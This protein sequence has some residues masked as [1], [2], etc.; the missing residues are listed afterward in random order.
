MFDDPDE[1]AVEIDGVDLSE[2][3]FKTLRRTVSIVLQEPLLFSGT[4]ASNLKFG[5]PEASDEEMVRV[6][7]LVG[8]HDAVMRL[9]DGYDT[10]IQER[11]TNLSYG[12]RQLICLGRALLPDPRILVFDEATS[13]VDPYTEALIQK[14]HLDPIGIE[15]HSVLFD[16]ASLGMPEYSEKIVHIQI[17]NLNR[18]LAGQG[19]EVEASADAARFLAHE[20]FDPD[21]GARPLKRTIQRLL[22]DPLASMVLAGEI[23]A[24]TR[25]ELVVDDGALV[26]RPTTQEGSS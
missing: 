2:M 19:L 14:S 25:I 26:L 11:G 22:Q 3:G 9:V 16:D 5:R 20:G 8:V 10:E 4:I 13:S 6:A 21:F 24:G 18:L 7:R 1:G 15:V 17:A 12:Q 23:G